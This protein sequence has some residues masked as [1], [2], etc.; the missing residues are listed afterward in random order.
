MRSFSAATSTGSCIVQYTC[1]RIR[2]TRKSKRTIPHAHT[3]AH[4]CAH[5]YKKINKIKNKHKQKAKWSFHCVSK[6]FLSPSCNHVECPEGLIRS[7]RPFCNHKSPKV[8]P[9]AKG[10]KE[11]KLCVR[12]GV[13]EDGESV[14]N[15]TKQNRT[16]YLRV[17]QHRWWAGD[18]EP[19]D[20]SESL[21][22]K[23]WKSF[24]TWQ[25]KRL[26]KKNVS[27][28]FGE[29][30]LLSDF[31][32]T[33]VI[34]SAFWPGTSFFRRQLQLSSKC[35]LDNSPSIWRWLTTT[36]GEGKRNFFCRVTE[37]PVSLFKFSSRCFPRGSLSVFFFFFYF[38][39]VDSSPSVM[40]N[41]ARRRRRGELEGVEDEGLLDRIVPCGAQTDHVG[42]KIYIKN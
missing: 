19:W 18:P 33:S 12:L 25:H 7:D 21:Q 15:K 6:V 38:C 42:K 17:L 30:L 1:V 4:T 16:K 2:H 3:S 8:C 34:L 41:E 28:R 10:K 31:L 32:L 36:T 11:K 23:V 26:S 5:T 20:F 39:N 14:Q 9:K 27:G 22:V 40:S 37:P 13:W 35:P 29:C 24:R